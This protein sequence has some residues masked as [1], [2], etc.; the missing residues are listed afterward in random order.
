MKG[1]KIG[2]AALGLALGVGCGGAQDEG[3]TTAAS[4]EEDDS[5]FPDDAMENYDGAGDDRDAI[6]DEAIDPDEEY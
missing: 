3:D 6:D 2:L 1:W 5:H 4:A